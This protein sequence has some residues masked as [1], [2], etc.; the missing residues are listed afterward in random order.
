MDIFFL[1]FA[2]MSEFPLTSHWWVALG[3]YMWNHIYYT[4]MCMYY[5]QHEYLYIQWGHQNIFLSGSSNWT[6][7]LLKVSII[8]KL[9]GIKHWVYICDIFFWFSFNMNNVHR[10]V[11]SFHLFFFLPTNR[12]TEFINYVSSKKISQFTVDSSKAFSLAEAMYG[13][14]RFLHLRFSVNLAI[15]LPKCLHA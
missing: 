7:R 8:L 10:N 14:Q 13:P 9:H 6:R 3:I 4:H 5:E 11:I 15:V 12:T 2:V 1:S